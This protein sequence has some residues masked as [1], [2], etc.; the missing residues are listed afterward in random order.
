MALIIIEW[1]LIILTGLYAYNNSEIV[2]YQY[3]EDYMVFDTEIQH[4]RAKDGVV[5]YVIKYINADRSIH[6]NYFFKNDKCKIID[7]ENWDCIDYGGG[8]MLD[9]IFYESR[10]INKSYSKV[11]VGPLGIRFV[12]K[13]EIKR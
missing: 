5:S 2:Y 10:R 9:G 3:K 4:L 11:L 7:N 12:L 6:S 13:D 8:Y 1:F